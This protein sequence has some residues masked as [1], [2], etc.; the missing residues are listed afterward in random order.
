MPIIIAT[1]IGLGSFLGYVLNDADHMS[2]RL[3]EL[4]TKAPIVET[5]PL[6]LNFQCP[7]EPI[8]DVKQTLK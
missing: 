4:E 7:N 5:T 2:D 3:K 6:I 1:I 8:W